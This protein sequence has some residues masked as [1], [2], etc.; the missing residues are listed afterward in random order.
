M[1]LRGTPVERECKEKI[2]ANLKKKP[3]TAVL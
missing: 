3:I 2:R 1:Q